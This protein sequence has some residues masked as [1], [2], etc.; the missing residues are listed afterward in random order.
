MD[1]TSLVLAAG[2]AL[3]GFLEYQKRESLQKERVEGLRKGV[4]PS[5]EPPAPRIGWILA[6]GTVVA[7][8]FVFSSWIWYRGIFAG[9]YIGAYAPLGIFFTAL[10]LVTLTMLVNQ[11]GRYRKRKA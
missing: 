11:I 8:L 1:W 10:A 4:L 2:I 5:F 7:I 6:T 9:K 3:Y